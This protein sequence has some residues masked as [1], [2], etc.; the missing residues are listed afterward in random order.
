MP[1]CLQVCRGGRVWRGVRSARFAAM[2]IHAPKRVCLELVASA[3]GRFMRSR[4]CTS[5]RS[6]GRAGVAVPW[7]GW[8]QGQGACHTV[9]TRVCGIWEQLW[10]QQ[11]A[12]G[13]GV[14]ALHAGL[15]GAVNYFVQRTCA[16]VSIS[17]DRSLKRAI[18]RAW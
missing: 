1:L 3:C 15:C 10:A 13:G 7:E 12:C 17:H 9:R 2:L 4:L 18:L 6:I 8:R 14:G 5:E 16:K 11:Q